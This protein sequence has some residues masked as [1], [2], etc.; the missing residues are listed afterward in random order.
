MKHLIYEMFSGVGFCN[1][2]FSLETAVYM[3][4][5]SNRK[6]ILLIKNPLCHCGNASWDFGHILDYFSDNYLQYLP[7]GL[8]V[9][10]GRNDDK[11]I[12][13]IIA[14][15]SLTKHITFKDRFSNVVFVDKDLD[16]SSE[17]QKINE[18]LRGR[19]KEHLCFEDNQN[20]DYIY[21]SQSNASRLLY[22]FY[23]NDVNTILMNNITYSFTLLNDSITEL[24]KEIELP[25]KFL[26]IHF[27]FGDKKHNV[28]MING[29]T[30][31]YDNSIDYN[32]IK[33]I[34]L[35]VYIMCDRRDS[36]MLEKFTQHDIP[37]VYTDDIIKSLSYKNQPLY[38]SFK[39]KDVIDF[40]IEKYIC[41]QSEVFIANNGSTVSNYINYV[42][43]INN[44]PYYHL[45]SNVQD[46]TMD[47]DKVSF[48]TNKGSGRLLTW[49]CFWTNN[50]IK[51]PYK[52]KIITLTNS[53]YRELT[54]N[55][56]LSLKKIGLMHIL[57]IYCLDADCYDH[58]KDKYPYNE[59]ELVENVDSEFANWI[60]YKA[61]Q[62]RDEVGKKKWAEV[63]VNKIIVINYELTRGNDVIFIDGDIIINEP[64]VKDLY[65][66]IGDNDLIIQSDNAD[67]GGRDCMCTGFFLMKTNSK[68][69]EATDIN[70]IDMNNFP[71]D[72]QYLRWAACKY[73]ITHKYLDLDLYPN[74][75]YYRTYKPDA[76][77]VH[78]NYDSGEA[79]IKRMKGFDVYYISNPIS[80]MTYQDWL[81][82]EINYLDVIVNSSVQ[83]CSDRLTNLAIGV[84]HDYL[85]YWTMCQNENQFLNNIDVNSQLCLA[86]FTRN[87]DRD[88]RG[89]HKINR[90]TITN[91]LNSMDFITKQRF[92]GITYFKTIGKFK[93][94]ISP[95]GNGI[96]THRH[97]EALYSKGIPII[98]DNL[99][100]RKKM[101]GLPVLWTHD[102]TELTEEYL[103]Q[104]YQEILLTKY[105][106]SYL[107]FSFYGNKQ[108]VE[109]LERSKHWC[110]K[111]GLGDLFNKHYSNTEFSIKSAIK[112]DV[113]DKTNRA[114]S[115][116]NQYYALK[117]GYGIPLDKKLDDLFKHKEKGVFVDVGAHDGINQSNTK[118]LED[119][120]KWNGILVT[121]N[122]DK[123][124]ESI[125]NRPNSISQQF[126][127]VEPSYTE[128]TI[129]GDFWKISGSRDGNKNNT[130]RVETV[131]CST[132]TNI[133]DLNTLDFNIKYSKNLANQIDLINIDTSTHSY[134]VLLGLDLDKY[135]PTY[136]LIEILTGEYSKI[137]DYLNTKGFELVSNFSSYTKQNH[138]RWDGTHND[139]LFKRV[140]SDDINSTAVP[141][142][143][144]IQLTVDE[145]PSP[146]SV[147]PTPVSPAVPVPPLKPPTV[148]LDT[149]NEDNNLIENSS[150]LQLAV[151]QIGSCDG[152]QGKD[153]IFS[154]VDLTNKDAIFVEPV[155]YIYKQL[156]ENYNKRYL[157]NSFKFI[158]NAV[159]T[160]GDEKTFYFVSENNNFDEI[161]NNNASF[162]K[163]LGSLNKLH[164][165]AH[166]LD[167]FNINNINK[168]EIILNTITINDII[169]DYNVNSI[170]FL[171]IDTEGYDYD[172]LMSLDLTHVK[173]KKI[174]FEHTHIN[175]TFNFCK[176]RYLDLIN[177]F[178]H[179]NY[180][181]LQSPCCAGIEN[182]FRCN[183]TILQLK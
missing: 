52:Y 103:N 5:I 72:Q 13:D 82:Y 11:E 69:I 105:D 99:D 162:V 110:F 145:L 112:P 18:Y 172:I 21:I 31:E 135:H 46:K 157:N 36:N 42:R 67:R 97:W 93:F 159:T 63:T 146:P 57:K 183:D 53:G 141:S 62:S 90:G 60:E 152:V 158:N 149:V 59:T 138:R 176:T 165:D 107:M 179:H 45:Y 6:L 174:M 116:G 169:N 68:T 35:P 154:H 74:G 129:K 150:K 80:S 94:V 115:D 26:A 134:E 17:A 171:H 84:Q 132:L 77:I 71:N 7:N 22:N 86:S 124:F 128:Q 126:A 118:Y 23:T 167:K 136:I 175:G 24:F 25:D 170:D 32:M 131:P 106:F 117:D 161:N 111:R 143:N 177:H 66:N 102:Y 100:M 130:N 1:Q 114:V 15:K 78:F 30:A 65:N 98:E 38:N 44:K 3:A 79:K 28:N 43:Y 9:V 147:S 34:G 160:T 108:R 8:K 123:Y 64:F 168:E 12:I 85:K 151:L 142:E 125:K 113:V 2:L 33:S 101:E 87:T 4:N 181:V 50:V 121:P 104:K 91:T 180:N 89:N 75:K 47:D 83:D 58:F 39:R 166:K 139:Y 182:G 49:Q 155:P 27:R 148:V 10:Y 81:S 163:E 140:D 51:N 29:R 14:D 41:E 73:N 153:P 16:T 109:L 120:R 119:K 173:P 20:Y 37:V 127:C 70:N 19:H 56:L 137:T 92:D 164:I 122:K 76:N 133:L 96:D 178:K 55:L 156:V 48:I 61:P 144:N 54:E 40:L 95:E 88:R